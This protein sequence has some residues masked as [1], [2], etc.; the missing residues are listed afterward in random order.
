MN[1][2]KSQHFDIGNGHLASGYLLSSRRFDF[3]FTF[4]Y[5]LACTWSGIWLKGIW[6][7]RRLLL[8]LLNSLNLSSIL[9]TGK[10]II[11]IEGCK[12]HPA[13]VQ[14]A[15]CRK[16]AEMLYFRSEPVTLSF[17]FQTWSRYMT[18]PCAPIA[19]SWN[20]GA[21]HSSVLRTQQKW[22]LSIVDLVPLNTGLIV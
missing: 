20:L 7:H 12:T 13:P 14:W 18:G 9:C 5:L 11:S 2:Q 6:I 1:I 15:P 17:S 19:K 10:S 3:Q 22:G 21:Q 4:V 16:R 8:S